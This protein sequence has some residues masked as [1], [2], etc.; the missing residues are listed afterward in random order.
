MGLI[1]KNP[2]SNNNNNEEEYDSAKECTVTPSPYWEDAPEIKYG[3]IDDLLG[4]NEMN[5]YYEVSEK[6]MKNSNKVENDNN[7]SVN[8]DVANGRVMNSNSMIGTKEEIF[9]E[10]MNGSNF[11]TSHEHD[12]FALSYSSIPKSSGSLSPYNIQDSSIRI[13]PFYNEDNKYMSDKSDISLNSP[14]IVASQDI[15]NMNSA[16]SPNSKKKNIISSPTI[17][18]DIDELKGELTHR[19]S[20]TNFF[21]HLIPKKNKKK[22]ETKSNPE[23]NSSNGKGYIYYENPSSPT[24]KERLQRKRR[25]NT[26]SVIYNSIP[27]RAPLNKRS[28]YIEIH[29]Y[30]GQGFLP[31]TPLTIDT[32]LENSCSPVDEEQ[33]S[34]DIDSILG[35]IDE[36]INT[37]SNTNINANTYNINS[38]N[39]PKN[40]NKNDFKSSSSFFNHLKRKKDKKNDDSLICMTSSDIMQRKKI[41]YLFIRCCFW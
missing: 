40:K 14:N 38:I 32:K 18:R 30:T 3:D 11:D 24:G 7:N 17:A 19:P 16:T 37:N 35:L 1:G 21:S 26:L 10:D 12:S 5:T 4:I 15:T 6:Q 28:S 31:L 13:T 25:S 23:L 22:E 27:K 20:I 9:N 33:N 36:D 2:N 39:S 8:D 34:C 29:Q 41:F